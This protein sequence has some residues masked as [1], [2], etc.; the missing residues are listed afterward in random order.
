ML[1]IIAIL[2]KI[3]FAIFVLGVIFIILLLLVVFVYGR[4]RYGYTYNTNTRCTKNCSKVVNL[5]E[6]FRIIRGEVATL[7]DTTLTLSIDSFEVRP[8]SSWGGSVV[9]YTISAN[10]IGISDSLKTRERC[11]A[12]KLYIIRLL[13]SDYASTA[14]FVISLSDDTI[15]EQYTT[16]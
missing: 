10:G 5:G 1:K 2:F 9:N 7:K 8:R 4:L 13:E 14:V 11:A 6:E 12:D 3:I 15:C 16:D